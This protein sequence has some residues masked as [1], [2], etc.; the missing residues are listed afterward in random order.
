MV[1]LAG[2]R[3]QDV[4]G[5]HVTAALAEG[6]TQA[7]EVMGRFAWWTGLGLAN[8]AN[9]FDP[10]AFVLGGGMVKA[11]EAMLAPVRAALVGLLFGA[12]H[13]PEVAVVAAELGERAGAVGAGFLAAAH[14]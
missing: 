13:R 1:E 6:D 14:P 2:G 7:S 3:V 12:D 10:Q 9:I 8:L 4:R 5:E 11:G